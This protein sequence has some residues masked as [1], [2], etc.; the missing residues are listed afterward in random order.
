ML[1]GGRPELL[2]AS[3]IFCFPSKNEGLGLAAI[4]AMASGLP[5]IT[6]NIQGI[7]DYSIDGITGFKCSPDD[8]KGYADAIATLENDK[9]LRAQMSE[10]VKQRVEIFDISHA[11]AAMKKIYDV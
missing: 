6:S 4:E 8:V 9:A 1:R 11:L 2:T 10:N 3:D 5:I 7:N